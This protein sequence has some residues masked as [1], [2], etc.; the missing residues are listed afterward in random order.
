[1]TPIPILALDVA[2]ASQALGVANALGDRC[3]YYKVGLELFAAEGPG[4]VRALREL[5][6]QVFLDLKLHDIPNTVHS[7][8]RAAARLGASLLTVHASG[9][10][11][12]VRAA[13]EGAGG[14]CG[15]LAVTVLTSLDAR[16]VASAWG[17][18]PGLSIEREVERLAGVADASGAHGVVCSGQ[19]AAMVRD[20]FADRLAT[21]VPG[22]RFADSAAHDQSRVVSP[23]Q[24]TAAGARYV[25][26]GRAVTASA[27]PAASMER[28]LTELGG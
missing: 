23:G 4:V 16:A 1:M 11:A 17:R 7:A 25:V 2:N 26:V 9:G 14:E 24:A 6:H 8:A 5:G 28:M 21:L 27:D 19:E 13:V 12:M 10:E 20:R 3:R 15:I 22:I 18:E